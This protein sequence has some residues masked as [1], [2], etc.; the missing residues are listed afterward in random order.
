[1]NCTDMNFYLQGRCFYCG[2][3]TKKTNRRDGQRHPPKTMRTKDHIIPY[4]KGG[5][6][7]AV[8]VTCCLKCNQN[9]ANLDLE[10]Y[11]KKLS[12]ECGVRVIFFGETLAMLTINL[13][14]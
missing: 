2:V 7:D 3:H 4:S 14:M 10:E 5:R 6:G 1:M 12:A 9:K 8:K 13:P 11:R